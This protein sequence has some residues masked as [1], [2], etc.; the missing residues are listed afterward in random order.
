LPPS[1]VSLDETVHQDVFNSGEKAARMASMGKRS[2]SK[3]AWKAQGCFAS[4]I[5]F[6]NRKAKRLTKSHNNSTLRR[7]AKKE[8]AEQT[9]DENE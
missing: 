2:L 3:K 8:I 9:Q 7:E 4:E 5:Q 1:G 6:I